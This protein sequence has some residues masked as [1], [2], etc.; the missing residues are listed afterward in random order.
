MEK[1]RIKSIEIE[2]IQITDEMFDAPHPNDLH[3]PGVIYDP[4]RRIV[5]KD[6]RIYSLGFATVGDWI[7]RGQLGWISFDNSTHFDMV[8]EKVP[9]PLVD[10]EKTSG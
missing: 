4:V 7:I 3:I 5:T 8:Y 1:F 2:A 6:E 10:E 9:V